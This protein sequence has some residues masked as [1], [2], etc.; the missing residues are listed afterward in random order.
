MLWT[1]S[2]QATVLNLLEQRGQLH[3]WMTDAGRFIEAEQ[4]HGDTIRKRYAQRM[5]VDPQRLGAHVNMVQWQRLG[6]N[7]ADFK[8]TEG[9]SRHAIQSGWVRMIDLTGIEGRTSSILRLLSHLQRFYAHAYPPDSIPDE[10]FML[11]TYASGESLGTRHEATISYHEFLQ[12]KDA[13]DLEQA[14]A[15]PVSAV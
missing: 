3:G 7:P 14:G 1:M 9:W 2:V 15:V 6:F 13:S 8:T 12:F 4:S 11:R 5:G 10:P